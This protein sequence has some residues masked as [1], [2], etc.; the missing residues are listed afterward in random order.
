MTFRQD[1]WLH[2]YFTGYSVQPIYNMNV[3]GANFP[4]LSKETE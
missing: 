4:S 2:K 3:G 1:S